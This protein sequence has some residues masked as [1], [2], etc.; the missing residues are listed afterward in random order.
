MARFLLLASSENRYEPPV[1]RQA[2][3]V[4]AAAEPLYR[5]AMAPSTQPRAARPGASRGRRGAARGGHAQ[6]NCP[7]RLPCRSAAGRPAARRWRP[8]SGP[9]QTKPAHMARSGAR[10]QFSRPPSTELG[11]EIDRSSVG[12]R[13]KELEVDAWRFHR[14]LARVRGHGHHTEGPCAE[15]LGALER[16][17]G[18][19]PGRVHGR[20]RGALQ[21]VRRLA[22]GRGGGLPA[23]ADRGARAPGSGSR[24]DGG[25][26]GDHPGSPALAR[27]RWTPRAGPRGADVRAGRS[28]RTLGGTPALPRVRPDS[29]RRA[30][31]R[32]ARGDDRPGRGDP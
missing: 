17:G 31:G 1:A 5:I 32:S 19:R 18:A 28:R 21:R 12:L 26:G 22:G 2:Q 30:G 11:L 27:A 13:P 20:L 24:S 23:R 6:G 9:S 8:C 7:A 14:A 25:L 10:S 4:T 16:G 15:C 3:N 29:R